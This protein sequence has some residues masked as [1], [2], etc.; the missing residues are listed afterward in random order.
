MMP[1]RK[2]SAAKARRLRRQL[3][4]PE[5]LLWRILRSRPGGFKF[6]RQHPVGPYVLDFFC[7][8][9]GL[10]VEVDGIAHAMGDNP[11]RDFRRDSWLAGQGI[12]T[13][14]FAA[15][16]VLEEMEAVTRAILD[17]C[18]RRAPPP[19]VGR[20]PSPANAGEE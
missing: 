16:D 6:R 18:A 2:P 10:A 19:P 3:T 8:E 17:A 12:R 20:S 13:I 5:G 9:A 15:S 7:F 4:L 1:I 11:Q 14:R